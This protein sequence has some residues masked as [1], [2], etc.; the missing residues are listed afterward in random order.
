MKMRNGSLINHG[1][2]LHDYSGIGTNVMVFNYVNYTFIWLLL[3]AMEILIYYIKVSPP[4][5]IAYMRQWIGAVLP[6]IMA[7]HL[8]GATS[9]SEPI[10]GCYQSDP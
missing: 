7:C 5:I 10:L 6:R 9:L 3:K 2:F 1:D 8:F 4:H